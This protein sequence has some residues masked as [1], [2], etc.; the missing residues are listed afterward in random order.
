MWRKN[1]ATNLMFINVN[2]VEYLQPTKEWISV[3][4]W[5]RMRN[6]SYSFLLEMKKR[7]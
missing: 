6:D 7:L 1:E 2:N 3:F 5:W 4:T